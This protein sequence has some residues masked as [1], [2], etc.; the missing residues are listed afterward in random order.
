MQ[1]E[2]ELIEECK[3]NNYDSF[4]ILFN[5]YAPRMK[6]IALRYVSN[7]LWADDIVQDSFI[8]IFN[9][10]KSFDS[11]G[12]FEGWITRITINTALDFI[13]KSKKIKEIE[14][15]GS[16][17]LITDESDLEPYSKPTIDEMLLAIEKLPMGY[18]LVFNMYII[19]GFP[20]KEI[21]HIL[22]ISE[23]TSKSQ[24]SKAKVLLRKYLNEIKK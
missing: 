13:K 8:K 15:E 6:G 14:K 2:I 9:K 19:D 5:K 22:K 17:H 4:K 1:N 7:S 23:G 12:S 24:L 21:A 10:I 18:K 20:H 16:N 11:K 3:D